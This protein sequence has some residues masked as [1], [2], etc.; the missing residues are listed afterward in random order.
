MEREKEEGAEEEKKKKE[1]EKKQKGHEGVKS[2]KDSNLEACWLS[3]SFTSC[4]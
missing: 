4:G 3:W 1:E 2:A